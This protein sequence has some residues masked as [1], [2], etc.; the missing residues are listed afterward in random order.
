MEGLG[1]EEA[2]SKTD[3]RGLVKVDGAMRT[4]KKGVYAIGDMV[5]GPRSRTRRRTRA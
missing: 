5:P 1:L 3:E 2:A 4:S